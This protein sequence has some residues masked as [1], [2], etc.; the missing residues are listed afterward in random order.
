MSP[1]D[2]WTV[3]VLGRATGDSVSFPQAGRKA[4][5]ALL[6]R[7][8]GS[9]AGGLGAQPDRPFLLEALGESWGLLLGGCWS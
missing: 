7:V 4:P 2:T 9:P 8:P 5:R 1:P 6:L 3:S